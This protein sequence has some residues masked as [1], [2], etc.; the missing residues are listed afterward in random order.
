[1]RLLMAH[2]HIMIYRSAAA[3]D[4]SLLPSAIYLLEMIFVRS[5]ITALAASP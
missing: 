3:G 2:G 5:Y 1:M 4:A